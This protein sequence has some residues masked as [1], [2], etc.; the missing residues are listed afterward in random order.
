MGSIS[1][2]WRRGNESCRS[3]NG[4]HGESQK[5]GEEGPQKRERGPQILIV[6]TV[7]HMYMFFNMG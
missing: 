5:K 3:R 2:S 4:L 6:W 7:G 1:G